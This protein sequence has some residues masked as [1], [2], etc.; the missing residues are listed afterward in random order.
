M[1]IQSFPDWFILYGSLSAQYQQVGNA[2]PV[3]LAF[4]LGKQLVNMMHL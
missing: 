2:V 4:H 1:R 3:I